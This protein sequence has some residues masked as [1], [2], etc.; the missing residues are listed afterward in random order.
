MFTN[1][2]LTLCE[3]RNM[4][5]RYEPVRARPYRGIR[6]RLGRK[7][8]IKTQNRYRE[9]EICWSLRIFVKAI[10]W[11]RCPLRRCGE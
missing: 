6:L 11:G 5:L 7:M 10:G 1:V 4:L 3:G 8:R 2:F 9:A